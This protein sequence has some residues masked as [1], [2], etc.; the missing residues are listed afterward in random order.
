MKNQNFHVFF[1]GALKLFDDHL[2]FHQDP[3]SREGAEKGVG[4]GLLR[5][6]EA[7]CL[8]GV[9]SEH[10]CEVQNPFIVRNKVVFC[11]FRAFCHL[12]RSQPHTLDGSSGLENQKI[13][14][15]CVWIREHQLDGLPCFH[16]EPL[17]AEEKSAGDAADLDLCKVCLRV[18]GGVSC[19][20]GR[21]SSL[22]LRA[23]IKSCHELFYRQRCGLTPERKERFRS[24]GGPDRV[25][26]M[27]FPGPLYCS[28]YCLERLRGSDVGGGSHCFK[29]DEL[30]LIFRSKKELVVSLLAA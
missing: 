16:L 15:R 27:R 17:L 25:I 26:K 4:A 9:W 8:G 23:E 7:Q 24:L 30:I 3:V 20:E 12:I 6:K 22:C 11:P 28:Q 5:C 2:T 29:T 19:V 1:R 14:G 21:T 18:E 10:L 13:M